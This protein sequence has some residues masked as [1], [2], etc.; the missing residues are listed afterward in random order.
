MLGG[1]GLIVVRTPQGGRLIR[2][3]A[4]RPRSGCGG[5]PAAALIFR[6]QDAL[7]SREK[8]GLSKHMPADPFES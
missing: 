5:T 3:P 8:F 4:A 2:A 6:V 7:R 1:G